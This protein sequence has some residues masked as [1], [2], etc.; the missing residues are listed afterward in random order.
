MPISG[1]AFHD[2]FGG[3]KLNPTTFDDFNLLVGASGVGKTQ[4]LKAI[5]KVANA[6][7]T[8]AVGIEGC[9]WRIEVVVAGV[10][11]LWSAE[12]ELL[13]YL[14][15]EED[16]VDDEFLGPEFVRE[17]IWRDD[18][19]L[20]MRTPRDFL[21]EERALPKLKATESAIS[22][23]R[24]ESSLTPLYR[25]L[26]SFV[27]SEAAQFGVGS[28]D[29]SRDGIAPFDREL[30]DKIRRRYPTIQEL[31]EAPGIQLFIKA[32]I[33]Q[34]DHPAEFSKIKEA[35]AEIFPTV[36]DLWLT[37][38]FS[39][40]PFLENETDV[41]SWLSLGIQEKGVERAI[42]NEQIS[43][44]MLR[45][46]VHLIE[47]ELTAPGTVIVV[48]EVEN[49]MGVN[50]LSQMTGHFLRHTDLQFIL[51]SHH[52]Y[53]I[54]NVPWRYWKLVTREGSVV[55]VKDVASIPEFDSD[56]SLEKFTQLMNLEE[57]EEAIR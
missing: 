16:V 26:S 9:E 24:Q 42:L 28:N 57:Y 47:L 29:L 50:C 46:L 51:T 17:T 2:V 55:T 23:L 31:R 11:Y 53:V 6:G 45:T 39:F 52:P 1:F 5:R 22:L 49:S 41:E 36:Q 30:V 12:T 34:K 48:D 44:G 10:K 37:E 20:V 27:F 25:A 14:N 8:E 18:Q 19:V 32:Y 35:Y 33:L 4:I 38:G 54:N 43:A 56:S 15:S 7:T 3:W 21:F 13:G 40:F